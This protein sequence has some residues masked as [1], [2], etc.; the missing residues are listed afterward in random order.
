MFEGRKYT[1]RADKLEPIRI[2]PVSKLYMERFI[3]VCRRMNNYN[4]K[5]SRISFEKFT[6]ASNKHVSD[7][8]KFG[9]NDRAN[10]HE[11]STWIVSSK[12]RNRRRYISN[13]PSNWFSTFWIE[14]FKI[15]VNTKKSELYLSRWRFTCWK[16]FLYTVL[17]YIYVVSW[18]K[19]PKRYRVNHTQCCESQGVVGFINVS[20]VLQLNSFV[21]KA[22]VTLA[23]SVCGTRAWWA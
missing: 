5:D 9:N 4:R 10:T 19:R 16:L 18:T 7:L 22:Y 11:C 3:K 17:K 21:E 2:V 12:A 13:K 23:T 14:Y 1:E 15:N 6:V 8:L 20:S